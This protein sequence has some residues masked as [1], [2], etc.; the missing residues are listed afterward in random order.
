MLTRF[1]GKKTF[2]ATSLKITYFLDFQTSVITVTYALERSGE[3]FQTRRNQQPLARQQQLFFITNAIGL[4]PTKYA[5]AVGWRARQ[6]AKLKRRVKPSVYKKTSRLSNRFSLFTFGL[7]VI[8]NVAISGYGFL[9]FLRRFKTRYAIKW[10]TR[11]TGGPAVR[12]CSDRFAFFVERKLFVWSEKC[13][14]IFVLATDFLFVCGVG[15][16]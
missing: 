7:A 3:C 12:N 14:K 2:Q 10:T 6:K 4:K 8:A 16:H 1:A 15:W 11:R 5:W 13:K 9:M